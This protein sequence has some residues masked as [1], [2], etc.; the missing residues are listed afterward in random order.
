[1]HAHE[2]RIIKE[3]LRAK[4]SAHLLYTGVR[5]N[6]IVEGV[7]QQMEDTCVI[8]GAPPKLAEAIEK[9]NTAPRIEHTGQKKRRK[10]IQHVRAIT[11]QTA[12]K[13]RAAYYGAKG[14]VFISEK[15]FLI[16]VLKERVP[17]KG[18]KV[19]YLLGGGAEES[20][21]SV[22]EFIF[23]SIPC[24]ISALVV[25]AESVSFPEIVHR[26]SVPSSG[27]FLYP[28]FRKSVLRAF[29]EF[30]VTE[31]QVST[32]PLRMQAQA[33]LLALREK[34]RKI[35]G[36]DTFSGYVRRVEFLLNQSIALLFNANIV[37]FIAHF[38]AA[39][40]IR[41]QTEL[42][43]ETYGKAKS[44]EERDAKYHS[45]T[46]WLLMEEVEEVHQ[47]A[48][49]IESQESTPPKQRAIES[50]LRARE[51]RDVAVI[52]HCLPETPFPGLSHAIKSTKHLNREMRKL[53]SA[54]S[55]CLIL[56]NYTMKTF[57]KLKV[58][59]ERARKRGK[60]IEVCVITLK[61]SVEEMEILEEIKEEKKRFISAIG[62]KKNRPAAVERK[63]FTADPKTPGAPLL[64][65]DIRELGSFLPLYLARS[66]SGA[67]K[68]KFE[69]LKHGDY[70]VNNTYFV[71]RKSI[72]DL[73]G[74]FGSGKLY[75]QLE[76]L[77]NIVSTPYLL[78][79]FPEEEAPSLQSYVEK[80]KLKVDLMEGILGILQ[81]IPGL[82]VITTNHE[83][84]SAAFFQ[85]LVR[86]P[87]EPLTSVQKKD[88]LSSASKCLLAVPGMSQKRIPAV[89]ANFDSMLDLVTSTRERLERV[90]GSEDASKMHKFFN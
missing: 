72:P 58:A 70:V 34:V 26:A 79:D 50:L 6:R 63:I 53:A 13:E 49:E 2:K 7:I 78:L 80:R 60:E 61:N 81:T 76:S 73:I 84:I 16:D 71:E 47:I 14:C 67:A 87:P 65:I 52:G 28:V 66:F 85:Y 29:G 45:L 4:R 55:P 39:T 23:F 32:D 12:A 90:F 19:V 1:M 36:R 40:D 35:P 83:K 77:K 24:D 89:L 9:K 68:F 41:A 56:L 82:R 59:R 15:I 38:E 3:V 46:S 21:K 75:S 17:E 54:N 10:A 27:I 62:L 22:R 18:V 86:R 31:V 11:I 43:A 37:H 48:R 88:F 51:N 5:V 30:E 33:N 64:S 42:L 25:C 8:V 20:R 74:S 69:M 57:R 44:E